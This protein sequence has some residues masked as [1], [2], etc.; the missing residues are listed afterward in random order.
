[1]QN[2]LN[3]KNLFI[4]FIFFSFS[5]FLYALPNFYDNEEASILAEK[6][7]NAMTEEE[8]LAQI[9]MFGWKGDAPDEL[10]FDWIEK[11]GLGNIK[12]FGWNTTN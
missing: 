5:V 12:V 4:L 2:I 7:A 9:F 8:M 10:L 3:K 6:I 11:R 1:M